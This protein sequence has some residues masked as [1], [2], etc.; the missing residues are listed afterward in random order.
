QGTRIGIS[1]DADRPLRFYARG[2]P[3]V[4]GPRSLNR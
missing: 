3:F 4:S 1:K 2:S